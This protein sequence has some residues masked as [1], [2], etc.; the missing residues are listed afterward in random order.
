MHALFVP[1][2]KPRFV[3]KAKKPRLFAKSQDLVKKEW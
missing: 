3:K 2:Q 1:L